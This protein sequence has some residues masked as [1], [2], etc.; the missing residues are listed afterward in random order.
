MMVPL[1]MALLGSY[2]LSII[3][4]PLSVTVWPQFAMQMDIQTYRRTYRGTDHA[5]LMM[6]HNNNNNNNNN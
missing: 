5:K 4:L 3:T 1:D 6:P 2:R